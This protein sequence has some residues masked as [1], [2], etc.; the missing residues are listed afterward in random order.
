MCTDSISIPSRKS[1]ETN[2]RSDSKSYE[3]AILYDA[4]ETELAIYV[5]WYAVY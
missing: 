3:E 4:R 2:V 1:N 5:Y